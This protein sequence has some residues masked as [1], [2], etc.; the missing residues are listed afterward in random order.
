VH[1]SKYGAYAGKSDKNVRQRMVGHDW[2]ARVDPSK[3]GKPSRVSQF[4]RAFPESAVHKLV[5]A[6]LPHR[7]ASMEKLRRIGAVAGQLRHLEQFSDFAL[8]NT[9]C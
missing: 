8:G 3:L 6:E 4:R 5:L 2:E 1:G 7:P 9:F